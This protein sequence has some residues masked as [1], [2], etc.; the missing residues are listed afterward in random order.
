MKKIFISLLCLYS[1]MALSLS[2]K[3]AEDAALTND[4]KIFTLQESYSVI[5]LKKDTVLAGYL[6]KF[7]LEL[8]SERRNQD[9][10]NFNNTA[11]SLRASFTNPLASL[12]SWESLDTDK[13]IL[14]LTQNT[15]RYELLY[16]I[17]INYFKI[18]LLNLQIAQAQKYLKILSRIF[19]LNDEKYKQGRIQILDRDRSQVELLKQEQSLSLL[20]SDKSTQIASLALKLKKTSTSLE[21]FNTPLA[22]RFKAIPLNNESPKGAISQQRILE[23]EKN[24]SEIK[25]INSE[26][27]PD[28]YL[29]L[30]KNSIVDNVTETRYAAFVAGLSWKLS[31]ESFYRRRVSLAENDLTQNLIDF[32]NEQTKIQYSDLIHELNGIVSSLI[33]Q[34]SIIKTLS[35][36]SEKTLAQYEKGFISFKDY[37]DDFRNLTVEEDSFLLKRYRAIEL[38]AKLAQLSEDDSIFHNCFLN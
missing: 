4:K 17:R 34:E 10:R 19:K 25:K 6:P 24:Q 12:A 13:K 30:Q 11:M 23:Y 26:F 20:N 21:K 37:H 33:S 8:S 38:Y 27:L 36:I 29:E 15:Y 32:E 9:P 7:T 28:F 18:Q 35:D 3:E 31:P 22:S 2:L 14:A 16:N 5:D 1:P